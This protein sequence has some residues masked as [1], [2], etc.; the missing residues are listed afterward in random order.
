MILA[1]PFAVQC[2][3]YKR[4]RWHCLANSSTTPELQPLNA[5]V[6]GQPAAASELTCLQ[7]V[8]RL[9]NSVVVASSSSSSSQG[10]VTLS[11]TIHPAATR[12]AAHRLERRCHAHVCDPG[13]IPRSPK[14]VARPSS[15]SIRRCSPRQWPG[16][17]LKRLQTSR[18]LRITEGGN[19]SRYR[20]VS[21]EQVARGTLRQTGHQLRRYVYLASS[22]SVKTK[23]R[24][25]GSGGD[26]NT[27]C[28]SAL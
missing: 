18:K 5:H 19:V 24:C 28:T 7:T 16:K 17:M 12:C 10:V 15:S 25:S 14:Q 1:R 6:S 27:S 26:H 21:G 3:G 8:Q 2:A 20:Q 13:L 9:V 11:Q 4:R 22:L 23:R